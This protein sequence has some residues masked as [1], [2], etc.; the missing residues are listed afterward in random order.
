M[1]NVSKKSF[2]AHTF[3][4]ACELAPFV[5]S[6][7]GV[8]GSTA[9]VSDQWIIT[10]QHNKIMYKDNY[11]NQLFVKVIPE[12]ANPSD[13]KVETRLKNLQRE[14]FVYGNII[15][16]LL[17][18]NVSPYFLPVLNVS[19][20]CP[21]AAL[22]EMLRDKA[23][24]PAVLEPQ[25]TIEPQ[26][27]QEPYDPTMVLVRNMTLTVDRSR[28]KRKLEPNSAS[29]QTFVTGKPLAPITN[30]KN[31][32]L[33]QENLVPVLEEYKYTL[34][35]T[36]PILSSV[37]SVDYIFS[38]LE[39]PKKDELYLF[40]F[41]LTI[42]CMIMVFLRLK[43]NDFHFGNILVQQLPKKELFLYGVDDKIYSFVT[44]H[45]PIVFDFDLSKSPLLGDELNWPADYMK[46][47]WSYFFQLY[48]T[49]KDNNIIECLFKPR[50]QAKA[51]SYWDGVIQANPTGDHDFVT[52]GQDLDTR[53]MMAYL[54]DMYDIVFNWAMLSN[55]V[56]PHSLTDP[57]VL[58]LRE[59]AS[60]EYYF[61][62][63]NF[64]EKTGRLNVPDPFQLL[65]EFI[66][67]QTPKN[68]NIP[69]I[70]SKK[71][72]LARSRLELLQLLL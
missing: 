19:Y 58:T 13:P 11:V 52:A 18:H 63:V 55:Q 51:K 43:H 33:L 5:R 68:V 39:K 49:T 1:G 27:A 70:I 47:F 17:D 2:T 3:V 9:S 41:Q 56:T 36:K 4:N 53:K 21:A 60:H 62:S 40:Y 15:K 16:P 45:I 28:F 57:E 29:L 37:T 61:G 64:D 22:I 67:P 38:V 34:L 8:G 6:V 24:T 20:N 12:I 31:R 59:M 50:H 23:P 42:A 46:D 54:N 66:N 30:S 65:E 7:Q 44:N 35:I 48:A 10:L 26:A 72:E 71:Q 14:I 69:E 25:A 32:E